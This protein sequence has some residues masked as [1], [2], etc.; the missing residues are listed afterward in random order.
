M[1]G[2]GKLK[3]RVSQRNRPKAD[4]LQFYIPKLVSWQYTFANY[5][6]S[7]GY[8]PSIKA[9]IR[10]D[11]S[12]KSIMENDPRVSDWENKYTILENLAYI[13]NLALNSGVIQPIRNLINYSKSNRLSRQKQ[14]WDTQRFV[15]K[16]KA[17][18]I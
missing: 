2:L 4:Y 3:P 15:Y 12:L 18:E 6:I 1:T 11:Q 8:I 5:S 16:E 17:N 7:F 13:E 14:A 9:A 10:E